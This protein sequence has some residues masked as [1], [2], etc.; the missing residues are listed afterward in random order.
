METINKF[1]KDKTPFAVVQY[2]ESL[3]S[4]KTESYKVYELIYLNSKKKL[5]YKNIS[6]LEVDFVK[7]N[8]QIFKLVEDTKNGKVY[9][10]N[11]FKNYYKENA[12]I[13]IPVLIYY[14]KEI[15]DYVNN[16]K[17]ENIQ[18]HF[19]EK[20]FDLKKIKERSI[21]FRECLKEFNMI[22]EPAPKPTTKPKKKP[23]PKQKENK[24][25]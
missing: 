14:K 24:D 12:I 15:E 18:K 6:E 1:L 22:F 5:G 2:F 3:K 8:T 4:L 7:R 10:C 21:V 9:E 16:I 20:M 17:D 23:K 19:K 25:E 13:E 11:N